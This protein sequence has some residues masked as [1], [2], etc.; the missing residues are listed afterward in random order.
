MGKKCCTPKISFVNSH[1][2]A[3]G[4]FVNSFIKFVRYCFITN[5][6]QAFSSPIY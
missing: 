1:P 6:L 4:P 3:L 5:L 2:L